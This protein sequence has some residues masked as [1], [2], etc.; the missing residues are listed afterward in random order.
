MG[1]AVSWERFNQA[2]GRVL[3]F[4]GYAP[5]G[6]AIGRDKVSAYLIWCSRAVPELY[7]SN[8]LAKKM[9]SLVR[10]AT[11]EIERPHRRFLNDLF[12]EGQEAVIQAS[13]SKRTLAERL[14]EY[15]ITTN[16]SEGCRIYQAARNLPR[17]YASGRVV[18]SRR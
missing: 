5:L 18:Y 1:E 9:R 6:T 4:L 11:N 15:A 8:D 2:F 14:K 12:R 13:K 3:R 7:F 16:P 17:R 10:T